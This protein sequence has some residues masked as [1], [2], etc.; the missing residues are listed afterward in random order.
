MFTKTAASQALIDAV[1]AVMEAD[2]KNEKKKLL[3]EPEKTKMEGM[4]PAEIIAGQLI[5]KRDGQR[6]AMGKSAL[7]MKTE[8]EKVLSPFDKGYKPSETPTSSHTSKKVS[9]G[10]VYQKKWT[11][12]N[13]VK[14]ETLDELSKKTLGSYI[15]KSSQ[16]AAGQTFDAAHK[17]GVRAMN[18]PAMQDKDNPHGDILAKQVRTHF[19]KA[20]SRLGGIS[21]AT[22]KLTR[23]EK[24]GSHED[25]KQDKAMFKKMFKKAEDKDDKSEKETPD[26]HTMKSEG[27]FDREN[28]EERRREHEAEY[29]VEKRVTKNREAAKAAAQAK[30]PVKEE[31]HLSPEESAEKERIVKGMKKGLPGFKERYGNRAKSVMYAT[32]TKQAMKEGLEKMTPQ[33]KAHEYNLDSAQREIDRRHGEGEDMTGAKINK[34]TYQIIKPKQSVAEGSG[35]N[36]VKSIKVGNFR[37]DLVDTGMGW[38]V[39]IH[40]GDELYDTGLSKNSEQKGLDSLENSVAHTEKQIRTKRQ[41]VAEEKQPSFTGSHQGKS[42]IKHIKNPTVQQRMFAHDIKPG[43]AGYRDRIA[44][45]K[46]AERMGNLKKEDAPPFDKPYHNTGEVK[47]DKYGNIVKNVAKHLAKKGMPPAPKNEEVEELDELNKDTLH[48]YAKKAEVDQDKQFTEIGKAIRDNDPETGNKAGHKFSKRSVGLTK[49]YGKL[50]KES[51][52]GIS[53]MSEAEAKAEGETDMNTKTVDGLR[54][55]VKVPATFHNSVRSYKVALKSEGKHPEDNS[56][57]FVTDETS[58]TPMKLAKELA[59]KS[60]KKIRTE[61]LGKD[62]GTSEE[63]KHD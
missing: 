34:T 3:L 33:Q 32:A 47:K 51:I 2:E 5:A 48:S 9:T 55:R 8:A 45:L 39:R 7:A 49:A 10:T 35:K 59:Q 30:K 31:R 15:K 13:P 24:E 12:E 36:V 18:G 17:L 43:V 40:N 6:A 38:Q 56:V 1:Q 44:V 61:T 53:S 27:S 54:G 11:P 63:T 21:K 19:D 4:I 50:E 58:H 25:E 62:G 23:E 29:E 28:R 46:D 22:D 20:N 60:F 14:E 26:A 41:G 37:H 16:H 57:P 52:G 42:T